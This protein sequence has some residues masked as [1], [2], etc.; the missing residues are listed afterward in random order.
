MFFVC[1]MP[2]IIQRSWSFRRRWRMGTYSRRID[3]LVSNYLWIFHL[4]GL[5][6][7][8]FQIR[9]NIWKRETRSNGI[10]FISNNVS[11][12]VHRTFYFLMFQ[13]A[14]EATTS[15][16]RLAVQAR[17]RALGPFHPGFDINAL[18]YDIFMRI[19]P[20][21]AHELCTGRLYVSLTRVS[22]AIKA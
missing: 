9:T 15:I 19:L 1:L 12:V 17:R 3:Y 10:F 7:D 20:E 8:S 14:G 2:P 4:I 22:I 21:N 13:I 5:C 18:L 16:L 11:T 6:V